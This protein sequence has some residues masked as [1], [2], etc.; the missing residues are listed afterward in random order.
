MERRHLT[1]R[2]VQSAGESDEE[3]HTNTLYTAVDT[4]TVRTALSTDA[5]KVRSID[6]GDTI[7]VMETGVYNGHQRGRIGESEWVSLV[8]VKGKVLA[9]LMSGAM[10]TEDA[11][12]ISLDSVQAMSVD[13]SV[14][15]AEDMVGTVP[16]GEVVPFDSATEYKE[17]CAPHVGTPISVE[18]SQRIARHNLR[19]VARQRN[20]FETSFD[21][22]NFETSFDSGDSGD[23]EN[24]Q[25]TE[26]WTVWHTM[27]GSTEGRGRDPV[28]EIR[29]RFVLFHLL[30]EIV[31]V[32][33]YFVAW[34]S[35][36]VAWLRPGL[37]LI[38]NEPLMF[39]LMCVWIPCLCGFVGASVASAG[40][41]CKQERSRG[42]LASYTAYGYL[43]VVSLTNSA[44][45]LILAIVLFSL[46]GVDSLLGFPMFFAFC[47]RAVTRVAATMFAFQ[48]HFGTNAQYCVQHRRRM[49]RGRNV[50]RDV[51]IM[52]GGN[53][54]DENDEGMLG[55]AGV[56]NSG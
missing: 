20:N 18:D 31:G 55:G 15:L 14:G 37:G 41:C 54:S 50:V 42:S 9:T 45:E 16:E 39:S 38:W 11:V 52:D 1:T 30:I 47:V 8:T 2:P 29:R 21:R 12:S 34:L 48:R 49:P 25:P 23:S 51:D 10:I 28:R 5:A 17:T 7:V 26:D 53:D 56:G 4:M 22:N 33:A 3:S 40:C 24:L 32:V 6:P 36:F 13:T 35:Y 44:F 27:C 43:S 19:L 46:P